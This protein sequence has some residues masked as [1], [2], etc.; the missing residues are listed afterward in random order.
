MSGEALQIIH[1]PTGYDHPYKHYDQERIPRYPAAG[2]P[3]TLHATVTGEPLAVWVEWTLGGTRQPDLAAVWQAPLRSQPGCWIVQFGPFG[4]GETVTYRWVASSEAGEAASERFAFTA[5][6]WDAPQVV[7]A[8]SAAGSELSLI[9]SPRLG[10]GAIRLRLA[11]LA[12]GVVR[13]SLA[14]A[15]SSPEVRRWSAIVGE[16]GPA[17][18]AWRQSGEA[19]EVQ[20]ADYRVQ[21]TTAPL[22][23]QVMD[24]SG[25]MLL[26]DYPLDP[27]RWLTDGSGRIHRMEWSFT[28]PPE[29]QFWGGGERFDR[30]ARRG[31][32]VDNTVFNQFCD[33]QDRTYMPVPFLLS[34]RGYGLYVD[35]ARIGQLDVAESAADRLRFS[36]DGGD[37]TDPHLDFYFLIAGAPAALISRF[38]SL[39]GRPELPPLWAF[40]PWM[41][42]NSWDRQAVVEQESRLTLDLDIPTSVLVIEAWSDEITFCMFNDAEYEPVADGKP[43]PFH[44]S[45][46]P[47]EG[48]WPDPKG[49]IEELHRQGIRLVLWQIP[50]WKQ[51]PTIPSRQKDLDEAFLIEHG[52]VVRNADGTPYR[53]SDEWFAQSLLIDFTNP[54][55]TAWWQERRRYLMQE[56]D[57]DGLKTDGG[58]FIYPR[59]VRFADGTRG[60]E[61]RNFYVNGYI[62]AAHEL[63]QAVRQGDG[64]TFSRSGYTGAQRFPMHWAGDERSTFAAFRSTVVAGLNAG[65][66]G[67]PFW[68]WDLAGFTGEIP[69]AE[70]YMRATAMAC[71]CPVM[72]YHSDEP[73][74]VPSRERTPWNIA[75]RTGTPAVLTIYRFFAHL[76]MNLM[77]YLYSQA[78]KSSET[79]LPMMR[80]LWLMHPHD[81]ATWSMVDQYYLGEDLLVAPVLESNVTSRSVYLPEGLWYDFWTQRSQHGPGWIDVATPQDRIPV[82]VRAGAALPLERAEGRALGEGM[83][84]RDQTPK[85]KVVR[86]YLPVS[87]EEAPADPAWAGADLEVVHPD[88]RLTTGSD[89]LEEVPR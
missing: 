28:T 73:K 64:L 87:L 44:T 84:N 41:S 20:T 32:T 75:E 55:A 63:V 21:V 8:V 49:M 88:G 19:W 70:L 1:I 10:S 62:Q 89:P 2:E 47:A 4:P 34:S 38:T 9:L 45:R 42:A 78:R 7:S 60:S 48:R 67:I 39:V 31:T 77:P 85:R 37:E 54:A 74:A 43:V 76:R 66:S 11:A 57:V 18:A 51:D 16:T 81:R 24:A 72:Q 36:F 59:D 5:L 23:V 82:F 52:Y 6:Y 3:V 86:L 26:Q 35:T 46:F 80:P 25:S 29:E 40:G 15:E 53:I 79:G 69:S 27:L 33:Q 65:I 61:G 13:A 22:G 12:D 30:V 56:L 68:G 71:F 17:A 50:V 14:F 58:E 83:G